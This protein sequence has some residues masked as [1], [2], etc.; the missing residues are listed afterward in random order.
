MDQVVVAAAAG[1]GP[2]RRTYLYFTRARRHTRDVAGATH[3]LRPTQPSLAPALP[4]PFSPTLGVLLSSL[5]EELFGIR[6]DEAVEHILD[7][8]GGGALVG[9]DEGVEAPGVE[10]LEPGHVELDAGASAP[11][12]GFEED[13]TDGAPGGSGGLEALDKAALGT[14]EDEEAVVAAA[15]AFDVGAGCGPVG[16]VVEEAEAGED[17]VGESVEGGYRT[18]GEG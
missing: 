3:V 14:V 10:K 5:P 2:L 11:L 1:I 4:S 18:H 12:A 17:F 6:C 7:L 9:D 16:E 15:F 8:V 13:E